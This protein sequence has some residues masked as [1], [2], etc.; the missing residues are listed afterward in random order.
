MLCSL[1]AGLPFVSAVAADD[2]V[3]LSQPEMLQD[4]GAGEGP[5]WH[6]RLGLLTSGEGNINRRDLAGQSS[7]FRADA[8][9]NGLLFDRQGRLVICD[10]QRRQ[11]QRIEADGTLRVLADSYQGSRFN[12][13]NDLTIDSKKRIYFTDPQYGDRSGME[14]L[15]DEGQKVE[16]VYRIDPDGRVTR[17]IAHEVDRPNGLIVTP[18]DQFLYVADNNNE[19]GG[20]R[21]L[22]RFDLNAD[23]TLDL[24][25][26]TLIYDWGTTRGPDGMKLDQ[27]GRLYVAA[28]LNKPRPPAQTADRPTAGIY[29][30]S[31]AGEK[32]DFLSIPRDE[33]TNCAFGGKDGKTLF[34]TA[35]GTLWS[36]RTAVPGYQ[37]FGGR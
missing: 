5:V 18:D 37:L 1:L 4:H 12:Q 13:P 24:K 26:Q 14:M 23:G 7:V 21:K 30:F 33:T 27:Q 28:G 25:T 19:L 22:W 15:D 3:F 32:I 20:A 36:V 8:G 16:G 29:V 35:G 9:S 2:P 31:P 17:I 34:V 6:P 10:N 11:V